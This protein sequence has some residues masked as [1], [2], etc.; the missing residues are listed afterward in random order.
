MRNSYMPSKE[1]IKKALHHLI[2]SIDD[3]DLLNQMVGDLVPYVIEFR[4]RNPVKS[5]E[6]D[7]DGIDWDAYRIDPEDP[8]A[9]N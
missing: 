4:R 9:K 5:K 8:G 1:D 3:E 2:D 7:M 6:V